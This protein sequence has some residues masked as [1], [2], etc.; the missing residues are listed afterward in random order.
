VGKITPKS[1]TELA[2]EEK[3]LRAI[4]GEKAADVKDSSL[5]VPS[6]VTGIVMDVKVSSRVDGE[7]EKLSPSDRRRQIKKINEEYRSQADKKREELTEALSNILLGEKIPLDVRNSDTGETII[8]ANRKITKTL[9]RRLAAV[10][11]HIE[12]D[13]S[14]VRI[15]VM[16]IVR[17]FQASLMSWIASVSA[18]SSSV[19]SRRQRR[20]GCH[21]KRKGLHCDQAQDWRSE[22]RWRVVTE[23]RVSLPES[24][25]KKTCLTLPTELPSK[26]V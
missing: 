26:S 12:I 6:G 17:N 9:L 22:T 4:F 10:S 14:P 2:P 11:K 8:P 19:E 25:R 7:L 3:L 18:R 1:E 15:K 23:T 21:Q 13:P 20:T 5:T 24:F 16:E